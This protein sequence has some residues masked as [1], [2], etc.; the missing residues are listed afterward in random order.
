MKSA[1]AKYMNK[2]EHELWLR[3]GGLRNYES[4]HIGV[5]EVRGLIM[6]ICA[7]KRQLE[8]TRP[9]ANPGRTME[10]VRR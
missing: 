2:Y 8:S 4:A 9:V 10:H 1:Y 5:G 6:T 7:L 3:M